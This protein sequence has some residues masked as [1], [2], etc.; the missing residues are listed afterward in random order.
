MGELAKTCS[1][2]LDILGCI[3]MVAVMAWLFTIVVNDFNSTAP[4]EVPDHIQQ[5]IDICDPM[6]DAAMKFIDAEVKRVEDEARAK[7]EAEANAQR[8][9]EF[10][11]AKAE[12]AIRMAESI[13]ASRKL[14][15]EKVAK[16]KEDTFGR[17]PC[18]PCAKTRVLN[19]HKTQDSYA[20]NSDRRYMAHNKYRACT[21]EKCK[22]Y[23]RKKEEQLQLERIR[24]KEREVARSL[25]APKASYYKGYDD[26]CDLDYVDYVVRADGTR[27]RYEMMGDDLGRRAT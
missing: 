13:E 26:V 15:E 6:L 16:H 23:R 7:R 17:C 20:E 12:K 1:E 2:N 10:A 3:L 21:C 22:E 11:K 18:E 9:K 19:S 24:A 5:Q 8:L 25:Y 4:K 14:E 27:T